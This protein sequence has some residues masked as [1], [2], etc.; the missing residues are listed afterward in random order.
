M[1]DPVRDFKIDEDGEWVTSNGDIV[2]VAG[3]EAVRQGIRISLGLMLGECFLEESAGTDYLDSINV[4]N[5]DELVVRE[6]LRQ[7]IARVPD[8]TNVVGAQLI[9][10]GEREASIEYAYDT[11]YS[12]D[13]LTEQAPVP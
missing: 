6:L 5:A 9:D 10:E 3:E 8:V 7:R 4:K 12:T 11:V 2:K 1:A 13:T